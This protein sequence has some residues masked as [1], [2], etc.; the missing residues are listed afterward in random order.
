MGQ[1]TGIV[2][3]ILSCGSLILAA[4]ASAS[5]DLWIKTR[6]FPGCPSRPSCVSSVATDA[7]HKIE[8][9]HYEGD[10]AAAKAKLSSVIA[11]MPGA[12]IEFEDERYIHA[13]FVTRIM[14]F[15]DDVELLV[16]EGGV[17]DVRSISRVG[18]GDLGV[19][20]S[21]VE[22]IRRGFSGR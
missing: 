4:C 17:I 22:A 14:R 19:N 6:Q 16:R 13:V 5:A 7:Q 10:P 21:R 1:R 18:Y 9:L 11:A 15:R 8:P 12:Q 20:R 2:A 3:A